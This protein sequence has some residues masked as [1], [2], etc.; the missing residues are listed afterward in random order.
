TTSYRMVGPDY[1]DSPLVT[2]QVVKS[3]LEL[4]FPATL[5]PGR[6]QL[7]GRSWSAYGRIARVET[8]IDGG[9]WRRV[10]LAARNEPA[11]WRQWSTSWVAK[12]GNH[13]SRVR[14]TD[15]RGHTQPDAVP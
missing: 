7:T 3:A 8:S 1:P 10:D 5:R 11:A 9:P 15:D 4:P 12:P 13:T 14:A 2:Q 6:R